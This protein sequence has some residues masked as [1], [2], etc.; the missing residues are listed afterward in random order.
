MTDAA[1]A[2]D[3]PPADAEV[4]L[5]RHGEVLV[6]TLHRPRRRNAATQAMAR[7]VAAALDALEADP[8][9]RVGI[10]TGAG[11]AFCS[12]MDLQRF[13]E[14]GETPV[15]DGRGFLGLTQWRGSKPLVAAVE[16][17]AVAGGFEAVLAC[18]L[19]VAARDAFFALAEVRRGLAAGAGGLLR[20]PRKLPQNLAMELALTG[21]GI[22]GAR[23]AQL[24][25]ASRL[26]EPGQALDVALALAARIAAN[27]PLSVAAAKRI[28]WAQRDWTEAEEWAMQDACIGAL[29]HT[30]DAAEGAR[31]F[32]ERRAPVWRGR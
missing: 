10:L 2:G 30:E 9:L 27:A 24:G 20:L 21:D 6:V 31:A 18:D 28:V 32:V 26:A 25:L 3:G 7:Q 15:L 4:L 5:Q 22:D 8:Q 17:P 16:G 23:A 19:V 12:G 13:A 11:G 29:E 14:H 1:S